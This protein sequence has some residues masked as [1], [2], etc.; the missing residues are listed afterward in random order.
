MS[1]G[2]FINFYLPYSKDSKKVPSGDQAAA[3]LQKAQE[4]IANGTKGIA[5]TYSANYGQTYEIEKHILQVPGIR[6]P[7]A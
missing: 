5:I 4:V 2:H 6:I 7:L 3:I 1:A